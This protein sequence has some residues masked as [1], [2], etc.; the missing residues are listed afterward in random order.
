[1]SD[2][3]KESN[4]LK[5][6]S[7]SGASSVVEINQTAIRNGSLSTWEVRLNFNYYYRWRETIKAT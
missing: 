1:M 6:C 7:S 4:L 2:T 5:N 3:F